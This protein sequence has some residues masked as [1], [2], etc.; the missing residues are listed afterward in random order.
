MI[1]DHI[2]LVLIVKDIDYTTNEILQNKL[3]K[4]H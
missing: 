2:N 4:F 1:C 3:H